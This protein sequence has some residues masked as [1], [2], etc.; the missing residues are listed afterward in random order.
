MYHVGC[1]YS[2]AKVTCILPF[3]CYL[4][5]VLDKENV[6]PILYHRLLRNFKKHVGMR[7][8][9]TRNNVGNNNVITQK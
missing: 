5:S 3:T 7:C 6:I 9:F 2:L 4:S 1:V 8:V